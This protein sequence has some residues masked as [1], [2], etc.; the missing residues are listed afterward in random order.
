M[1][2][3]LGPEPTPSPPLAPA[4]VGGVQAGLIVLLGVVALNGGNYVFHL[5]VAR[6]LGTDRYGDFATLIT[7]SSLI[8]LPLGGLQIW[9]ARYVARADAAGQL[10]DA[11][12][13]IRR[14]TVYLTVA[15]AAG[16]AI[17][18][19][20]AWPIQQ[21]LGLASIGA[22]LVTALTVGPSV[23]TPV[24]WG[25]AQGL[26]RFGLLAIAYGSGPIARLG[27]I[28][29]TLAV[30]WSVGGAML[31]TLGSM[32]LAM[33]VPAFVLRTW[34]RPVPGPHTRLDRGVAARSLL[35][36][37]VGLLAITALTSDDVV[38]AKAALSSHD[39]GIY[40]SAS[41]VGR[42]IL[43][44]P[45]AIITVLLPRVAAR[46]AGRRGTQDILWR[47]A[48]VT[49]AFCLAGTAFYAVAGRP[50]T[51]IAFGSKYS[52]AGGLLWLFG[53]AMTGFALLNVLLIYHLGRDDGRMSWLL[54]GGAALQL[55]VFAAIHRTLRELI[56]VDIAIAAVLLALHEMFIDPALSRR[57]AQPL[58]RPF[59]RPR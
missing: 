12:W 58:L 18:A 20:L 33:L 38:V 31:A 13:F 17:F 40:D 50:I 19:A 25:L 59:A 45:A 41:L 56:F 55:V 53:I 37:M 1:V 49:V 29:A 42:A 9:V 57:V 44:L 24:A 27:L 47:S 36:V 30:G 16:T 5:I 54:L 26:E 7:L 21:A 23:L 11:H 34:W 10:S 15:G 39:A 3:D 6:R 14:T 8:S 22:V 28:F 2:V 4:R 46:F 48:G 51:D 35:P 43:Y 32:L 52:E